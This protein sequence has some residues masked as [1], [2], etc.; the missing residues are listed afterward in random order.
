LGVLL[1][2]ETK[3]EEMIEIMEHLHNYVPK[4][5]L[6]STTEVNNTKHQ[7]QKEV[8]YPIAVTG[9]QLTAARYRGSK[10]IRCNSISASKRLDGLFPACE[11]WHTQVTLLKV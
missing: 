4:V 11:D 5:L 9:D 7:L 6:T 10:T 1:K 8:V 2:N 3:Y